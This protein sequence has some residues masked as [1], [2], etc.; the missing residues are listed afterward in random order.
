MALKFAFDFFNT[1]DT[2]EEVRAVARQLHAWGH[3]IHIVSAISPGLPYNYDLALDSLSIPF[4][5]VHRV[6]HSPALKVAVLKELQVRGFWDDLPENVNA[7]RE[8]GFACC[9]VGVEPA[10][11]LSSKS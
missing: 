11:Q 2:H 6:D 8:A 1:L 9:L 3:E 7:A 4:T 10:N 5:Q